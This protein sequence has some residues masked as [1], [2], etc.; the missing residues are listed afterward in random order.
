MCE[1]STFRDYSSAKPTI[2]VLSKYSYN[3]A[4]S[5]LRFFQY[6]PYM[7]MQG[8]QII[9]KPFFD[10]QYVEDLYAGRKTS[11]RRYVKFYLRRFKA[12]LSLFEPK[13]RIDL[14]IIEKEALPYL[15][16]IFE[17][18]PAIA[19]VPYIV[20]FD[21]A[22]FHNYE[23]HRSQLVRFVLRNKLDRL[24]KHASA[25]TAGNSYLLD[26]AKDH[27]ARHA[28]L[29]PTVVDH[30]LYSLRSRGESSSVRI[31]WIGTPYTS[32]YL[33]A[34]IPVI[35]KAAQRSD[36]T[37]VTIGAGPI[38]VTDGLKLEQHAWSEDTE[39]DLLNTIDIGLMPLPDEPFERGKCGYK[40]IQY[41]ASGA[42]VIGSPV[43]V[44]SEIVTPQVGYLASTEMQWVAAL[45]DLITNQAKR[46][47]MGEA[48]Q[49]RVKD[50][51]SLHSTAEKF[52]SIV[53]DVINRSEQP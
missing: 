42:A 12:L 15:P 52:L 26:Y 47:S 13:N 17:A 39:C 4:S 21:D 11:F 10:D 53:H 22:I 43:G 50:Y 36:V 6:F 3:G 23:L 41:M 28:H 34:V 20:D 1:S 16:G 19:G 35:A 45:D 2:V 44:N 14:V 48:G 9:L 32:K 49:L 40:L 8:F 37:L 27:G 5:R 7:E 25:V 33:N 38:E 18:I 31:G 24:M 29:I 46:R 30:G 51:Y